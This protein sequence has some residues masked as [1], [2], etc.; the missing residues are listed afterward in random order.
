MNLPEKS[1]IVKVIKPKN[2]LYL[3]HSKERGWGVFCEKPIAKGRVIETAPII[4]LPASTFKRTSDTPIESYRFSFWGD[5]CA[6]VLG[7]GSLYNHSI[8]GANSVHELNRK[9]RTYTFKAT[10]DIPAHTEIF[11]DYNWDKSE[12]TKRGMQSPAQLK[13]EREARLKKA[14]RARKKRQAANTKKRLSPKSR[15]GAKAK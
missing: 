5:A 12:Y 6:L 7:F 13:E 10:K 3:K 15:K 2:P 4:F 11:H 9:S 1:A 14:A 8:D